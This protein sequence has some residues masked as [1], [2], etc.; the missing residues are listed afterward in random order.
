VSRSRSVT[1]ATM[2]VVVVDVVDVVVVVSAAAAV[3]VVIAVVVSDYG[4]HEAKPLALT[5]HWTVNAAC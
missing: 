3:S 2:A 1:M 4:N 5:E